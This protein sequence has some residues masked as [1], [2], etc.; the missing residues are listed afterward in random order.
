[1]SVERKGGFFAIAGRTVIVLGALMLLS[2]CGTRT[3]TFRY[4]M[5][6]EVETPQG[7][8]T[9]SSVIEV[10]LS[11]PGNGG[12]PEGGASAKAR[13]EAVAVVLPGGKLLVALLR[14]PNKIDGAVSY[15]FDALK[16]HRYRGEYAII[17][18][19]KDL[20]RRRK[21]GE[22]PKEAYPLFVTFDDPAN[23]RSAAEVVPDN[24][25]AS[26]GEG[27]R[28]RR[29][30][31]QITGDAVQFELRDRLPWL[32]HIRGNIG[33]FSV[34]EYAERGALLPISAKINDQDFL[35]DREL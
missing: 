25:P 17:E 8:R 11:D 2:A 21:P 1:M 26:F 20:K 18:R 6:V 4:R 29:V 5:T 15:P 10:E 7:L 22:L 33:S 13:G 28:L 34:A 24:L 32:A 16:P 27:A 14:T 19:T 23:P 12:L 30:I 3:E 9:G 31:V 35:Q